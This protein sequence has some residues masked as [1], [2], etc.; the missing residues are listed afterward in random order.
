MDDA[1]CHERELFTELG[2][3][4]HAFKVANVPY[5]LSATPP[6]AQARVAAL[7]EHTE[8]V[9]AERLGLNATQLAACRAE[10]VFGTARR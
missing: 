6:R 7:G 10:G 2:D 9:L 5:R 4:D 3:G 1:Q 8:A